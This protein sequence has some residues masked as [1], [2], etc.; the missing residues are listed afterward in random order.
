MDPSLSNDIMEKPS[1]KLER[2]PI[3]NLEDE[4]VREFSQT[5]NG[6][7]IM[8]DYRAYIHCKFETIGDYDIVSKIDRIFK[9]DISFKEVFEHLGKLNVTQVIF[10]HELKNEEWTRI[11]LSRIHDNKFWINSE[12]IEI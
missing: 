4:P 10:H 5:I 3:V 12:P 2:N 1:Y 7:L 9:Q 11:I 8:E 6:L